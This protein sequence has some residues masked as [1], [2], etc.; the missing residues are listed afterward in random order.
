MRPADREFGW[1]GAPP[2]HDGGSDRLDGPPLLPSSAPYGLSPREIEI[3]KLVVDGYSSAEIA[4][5][6]APGRTGK[7]IT[8]NTVEKHL[9]NVYRKLGVNSRA[10]AISLAIRQELV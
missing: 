10:R 3:L 8:V 2:D 1:P 7:K 9:T 6:L 5:V 4:Q